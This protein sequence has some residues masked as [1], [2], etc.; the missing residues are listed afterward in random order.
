M[1][2]YLCIGGD[3]HGKTKELVVGTELRVPKKR[4]FNAYICPG[5]CTCPS[6]HD[7]Y[8]GPKHE[9][10]VVKSVVLQERKT[11]ERDGAQLRIEVEVCVKVLSHESVLTVE[12]LGAWYKKLRGDRHGADLHAM[13]RS[14]SLIG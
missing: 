11:I 14:M 13:A 7:H 6:C 10:Y 9:T 2:H 5:P 8:H 4:D 12:E 3:L 1:P